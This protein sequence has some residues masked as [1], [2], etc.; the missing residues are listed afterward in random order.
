M[1]PAFQIAGENLKATLNVR[2]NSLHDA[3]P[4]LQAIVNVEATGNILH[5][6]HYFSEKNICNTGILRVVQIL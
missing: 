5:A 1:S 2:D 4:P 3:S 6:A